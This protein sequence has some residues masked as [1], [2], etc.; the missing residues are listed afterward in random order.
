MMSQSALPISDRYTD[1]RYNTRTATP[2]QVRETSM[3]PRVAVFV[4]GCN[5]FYMQKDALRW[6]I[7]P[8]KLLNAL[9]DFGD[10]VDANYYTTIDYHNEGQVNFL[11]ALEHMGFRVVKEAIA[12]SEDAYNTVDIDM[13]LDMVTQSDNYDLAIV[14]SGDSAFTKPLNILRSRGKRFMVVATKG[15][16]SSNLRSMA[17]MN[18]IDLAD[19][20]KKIEKF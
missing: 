2:R 7:D 5:L 1:D 6:F 11:R 14:I 15:C 13:M 16:V 4:D 9:G 20:R 10:I 8:R 17:G 18:Y 12:E 19:L 3:T